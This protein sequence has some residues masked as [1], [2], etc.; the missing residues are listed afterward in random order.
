[1]NSK[2]LFQ[3]LETYKFFLIDLLT[4]SM[5]S[6]YWDANHFSC[7]CMANFI[8]HAFIA[9]GHRA[10]V[11]SCYAIAT[12]E[13]GNWSLGKEGHDFRLNEV[14]GHVVT[15]VDNAILVDFGLGN[16]SR[17]FDSTFPICLA[18]AVH[19]REPFPV[20][21][22]IDSTKSIIWKADDLM[23]THLSKVISDHKLP[24]RKMYNEL[25]A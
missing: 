18:I 11:A 25:P 1:M 10:K 24:A 9:K 2:Y 13:K 6:Q 17:Y 4:R 21:L 14:D 7:F 12:S 5:K 22:Q 8:K 16:I 3:V 19:S 23:N 15:I 20:G